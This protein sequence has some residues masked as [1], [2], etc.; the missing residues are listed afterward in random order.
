MHMFSSLL[1][2]YLEA[3]EPRH[4]RGRRPTNNFTTLLYFTL[5]P[6]VNESS[7]IFIPVDEEM[8]PVVLVSNRIAKHFPF[9]SSLL[10]Q[11]CHLPLKFSHIVVDL[12]M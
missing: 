3:E 2:K 6:S 9:F 7:V 1:G 4:S 10:L 12:E 5:Q 8:V 11:L